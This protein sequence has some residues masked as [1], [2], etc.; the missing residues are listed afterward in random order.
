MLSTGK[1]IMMDIFGSAPA[2]A[3]LVTGGFAS[4]CALWPPRRR[5]AVLVVI[6]CHHAMMSSCHHATMWWHQHATT[7]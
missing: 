7:R 1:D 4:T 5:A 3:A 6:S 2:S